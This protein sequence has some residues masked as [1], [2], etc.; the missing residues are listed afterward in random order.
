M[1]T[2]KILLLAAVGSM[3]VS[4]EEYLDVKPD[5]KLVVPATL[6]DMN[7]L[8]DNTFMNSYSVG[9]DVAADDYYHT[10]ADW[11]GL[12]N[13]RD[14][15]IYLWQ[16]NAVDGDGGVW[17]GRYSI[18]AAANVVLEATERKPPGA[19][20]Q[21]EWNRVKAAALFFRGY[22][23]YDLAELFAKPYDKNTAN[24]DLGIPLRLRPD[25]NEKTVRASVAQTYDQ[26]VK[27]L[28]GAAQL[29]PATSSIATRPDKAA[30]YGALARV[31]L[32]MG[33]FE[34]AGKYADSSLTIKGELLDFNSL[35]VT[36]AV[37]FSRLNKE[38]IFHSTGSAS[39]FAV[40]RC[41]VDST[42]LQSYASNDL[43]KALFFRQNADKTYAFK[44]SYDGQS[45][46]VLFNGM[47]TAEMYLIRAE[48]FART[49]KVNDGRRELL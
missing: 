39:N 14:R 21:N 12:T 9:G 32:S 41:R 28:R 1:K 26:I 46:S 5:K 42:L 7:A 2:K 31:H 6:Q 23:F 29:L 33:L 11:N 20:E 44:G 25:I 47:T 38:V 24:T 13:V 37:P 48:G 19:G 15:N 45:S 40:A 35:N 36:A 10:A 22:A 17:S 43:R 16:N 30:A 8:L 34:E 18:V 49:G 27:D 3:L 4:C